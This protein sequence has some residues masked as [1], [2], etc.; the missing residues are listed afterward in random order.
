MIVVNVRDQTLTFRFQ[1]VN[2]YR[3]NRSQLGPCS[4]G[5]SNSRT[6]VAGKYLGVVKYQPFHHEIHTQ[7]TVSIPHTL[8]HLRFI[9]PSPLFTSTEQCLI[10]DQPDY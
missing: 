7:R 6:H 5:L 3:P 2:V 1:F 8:E 4:V 10:A 9:S